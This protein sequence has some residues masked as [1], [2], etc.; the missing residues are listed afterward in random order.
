MR[1]SPVHA[2][3]AGLATTQPQRSRAREGLCA[4]SRA[5]E[6]EPLTDEPASDGEERSPHTRG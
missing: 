2:N 3:A 6:D 1:R 5:R 4:L